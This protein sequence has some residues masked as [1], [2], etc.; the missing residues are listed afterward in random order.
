MQLF[1]SIDRFD[2]GPASHAEDSY[3]YYNR[4]A[5]IGAVRIRELLQ[6]WFERYPPSEQAELLARFRADFDSAF[7]ELFLHEM[8][9]RLGVTVIP[10]PVLPTAAST[11]PDFRLDDGGT[12]SYLE[13]RVA[14]DESSATT[15][16]R[17]VRATLY[18]QINK[19]DIPEYFLRIREVKL[20]SDRQPSTRRLGR[21][22]QAW[23][24][25]LD[26]AT[27]VQQQEELS[28]L[29]ELPTWTYRDESIRIELS[30]M[31]VPTKHRG[32]PGHRPIGIYPFESRWGGS[33]GSL[34]KALRRKGTKYGDLGAPYIIAI[35]SLSSWGFNR[36]DQ[37]EALFG[38]EQLV[39]GPGNREPEMGRKSDGFW[40]G[41]NGPQHTRVSAVLYCQVAP[42]HVH[43]GRVCLY[44]NPFAA[45]RYQGTLSALP[46]ALPD[47]GTMD[48][49]DGVN[50]GT[51]F[52]LAPDWLGE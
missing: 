44:H 51:L 13:A 6:V 48:W 2:D 47:A 33:K 38:S 5:R 49:V 23:L 4:S 28:S 31:P 18:D 19:L 9:L 25:T 42:W 20:L 11:R 14:R 41:P 40:H 34:R 45:A 15:R 32:L 36:N 30:A 43:T 22:L 7:F 39:I 46:Q 26:Y 27:L 10:H 16:Q 50:L 3:S 37:M 12:I 1:E 29:D 8:A 35:N 21:E 52:D 24:R 17:G